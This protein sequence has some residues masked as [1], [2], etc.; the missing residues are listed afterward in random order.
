MNV[1]RTVFLIRGGSP[2]SICHGGV[3]PEM[4]LLS[5][6]MGRRGSCHASLCS[7]GCAPRP[8]GCWDPRLGLGRLSRLLGAAS[9]HAEVWLHFSP[10]NSLSFL[11]PSGAWGFSWRNYRRVFLGIWVCWSRYSWRP[12]QGPFGGG[13][14][15]PQLPQTRT[16]LFSK[17]CLPQGAHPRA[18]RSPWLG[19]RGYQP[20]PPLTGETA[21]WGLGPQDQATG[22]FAEAAPSPSGSPSRILS[23]HPLLRA[24]TPPGAPGSLGL[25][26][27]ELTWDSWCETWSQEAPSTMGPGAATPTRSSP[28]GVDAGSLGTWGGWRSGCIQGGGAHRCGGH[29]SGLSPGLC[30]P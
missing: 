2:A 9:P 29:G 3:C 17:S 19:G 11:A 30:H 16:S 22:G 25:C 18:A 10:E 7:P 23:S 5:R 1:Q 27:W 8:S 14:A 12:T 28:M 24:P 13:C 15:H 6:A 26:V 21:L 20:R 4:C